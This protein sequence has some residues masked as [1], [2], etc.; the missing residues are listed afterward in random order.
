MRFRSCCWG[1]WRKVRGGVCLLLRQQHLLFFAASFLSPPAVCTDTPQTLLFGLNKKVHLMPV[2]STFIPKVQKTKPSLQ[3][4]PNSFL[5]FANAPQTRAAG[6][7]Q[8]PFEGFR[9]FRAGRNEEG[10]RRVWEGFHEGLKRVWG[11]FDEGLMRVWKKAKKGFLEKLQTD[12]KK[13]EK[14]VWHF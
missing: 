3:A 11:G 8:P 13:L 1:F 5:G 14:N 10:L 9:G 12:S 4:S 6:H 7:A 2:F